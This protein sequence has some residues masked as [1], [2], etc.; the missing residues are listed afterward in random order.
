MQYMSFKSGECRYACELNLVQEIIGDP[1]LEPCLDCSE[2]LIGVYDGARGPLP[3]IDLLCRPP[4]LCPL[5]EMALL[6]FESNRKLVGLLIDEISEVFEIDPK[7]VRPLASDDRFAMEDLLK[8]K[9]EFSGSSYYL[10]DPDRIGKAC[11]AATVG[12]GHDMADDPSRKKWP[13][14]E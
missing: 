12:D 7:E 8:G 3:V 4:D 14:R 9:I 5:S 13:G 6:V 2:L 10:I 11:V 1:S